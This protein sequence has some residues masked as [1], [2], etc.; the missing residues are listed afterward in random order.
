MAI[1]GAEIKSVGSIKI[2]ILCIGINKRNLNG[3]PKRTCGSF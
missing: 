3:E 2:S 1:L